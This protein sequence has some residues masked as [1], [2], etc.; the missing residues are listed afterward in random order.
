MVPLESNIHSALVVAWAIRAFAFFAYREFINWP[1]LHQKVVEVNDQAPLASK[2]VCWTV[3]PFLYTAMVVPCLCRLR[4]NIAWG[5][6]GKFAMGLQVVGLTLETVADLQKSQFKGQVGQRNKWCNVGLWSLFT[7]PN[8]LGELLFWY[9]TFGAG[10]AACKT[11]VHRLM[12]IVG[13]VFINVV[14]KGAIDTLGE[15]QIRKYGDMAEFQK[16]RRSHGVLGPKLK[17]RQE[18][19]AAVTA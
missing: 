12:A 19:H 16:F 6:V 17:R 18:S 4:K 14:M 13:L 2:L 15:K 1:Q 7:H 3:L 9:G 10:I 11:H 8:Y 5:I